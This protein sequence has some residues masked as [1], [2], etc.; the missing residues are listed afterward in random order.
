MRRVRQ[1]VV[2]SELLSKHPLTVCAILGGLPLIEV[3]A[4]ELV[5]CRESSRYRGGWRISHTTVRAICY[6]ASWSLLLVRRCRVWL[7]AH[8]RERAARAAAVEVEGEL[9]LYLG[10]CGPNV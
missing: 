4:V 10:V 7:C 8:W 5:A 1:A 2:R 9:Q 6:Y 3:P